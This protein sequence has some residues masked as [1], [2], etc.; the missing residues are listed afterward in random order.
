MVSSSC[1][2]SLIRETSLLIYI[3]QALMLI[4]QQLLLL[5]LYV[6]FRPLIRMIVNIRNKIADLFF[7]FQMAR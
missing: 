3:D 5:N 4:D 6:L 7:V 1:G 2:V